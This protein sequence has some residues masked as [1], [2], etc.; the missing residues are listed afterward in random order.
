MS[1]GHFRPEK[2]VGYYQY[3]APNEAH[4]CI[5]SFGTTSGSV[6]KT[7]EI[8]I[9]LSKSTEEIRRYE[10]RFAPTDAVRIDTPPQSTIFGVNKNSSDSCHSSAVITTVFFFDYLPDFSGPFRTW[11]GNAKIKTTAGIRMKP[12]DFQSSWLIWS[13]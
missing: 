2:P 5:P 4:L 7:R 6:S 9:L 12:P 10:S 11:S 1:G 3:K 13:G 8:G